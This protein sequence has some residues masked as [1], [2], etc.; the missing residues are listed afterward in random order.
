MSGFGVRLITQLRP[1]YPNK[2]CTNHRRTYA[3]CRSVKPCRMTAGVRCAR[4]AERAGNRKADRP[5]RPD[6]ESSRSAQCNWIARKRGECKTARRFYQARMRLLGS[7]GPGREWR[8]DGRGD[9]VKSRDVGHRVPGLERASGCLQ[10]RVKW[11][12]DS[13]RRMKLN[14]RRTDVNLLPLLRSRKRVPATVENQA[15]RD[16]RKVGPASRLDA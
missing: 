12:N 7:G 2:S 5:H 11:F 9:L 10:R 13:R 15:T 1:R 14:R 8:A 3:L 4:V 6:F 16:G